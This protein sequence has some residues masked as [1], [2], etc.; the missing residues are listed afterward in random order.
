MMKLRKGGI[1]ERMVRW[2]ESWLTGQAQRV[3]I[4]FMSWLSP[5]P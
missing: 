3:V 5:V 4:R 2:V 1:D